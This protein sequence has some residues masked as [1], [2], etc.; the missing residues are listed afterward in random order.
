MDEIS[1]RFH[2]FF[3][4]EIG[5]QHF[6]LDVDQLQGLVGCGLIDG[7]HAGDVV[8]HVPDFVD[9]QRMFVVAH[10]KNSIRSG[11]VFA[12]N[13]GYDSFHLL[14]AAGV[15]VLNARV[16]EGRMQDSSHQHAGHGEVVG[17]FTGAGGLACGVHHGDG[18]PDD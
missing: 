5:R 2:C 7:S 13:D 8:T 4:I 16:G 15:N 3:G 1:F 12:G 18:F 14:G 10:R 6:I 11:S 17:V 9:S